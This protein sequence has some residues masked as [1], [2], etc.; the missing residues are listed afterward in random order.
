MLKRKQVHR[1]IRFVV[2]AAL[3]IIF[4]FSASKTFLAYRKPVVQEKELPVYKYSQTGKINYRAHL[5][6]NNLYPAPVLEPGGIYLTSFID[7]IETIFTYEF[8]GDKNARIYGAYD[9]S[10]TLEAYDTSKQKSVKIWEKTFPL[11]EQKRFDSQGEKASFTESVF[12]DIP[13]YN[14]F[15]EAVNKASGINAGEAKLIVRCNIYAKAQTPDGTAEENIAPALTIPVGS[16]A[17]SIGPEVVTQKAGKLNKKEKFVD[18][19]VKKEKYIFS[20]VSALILIIMLVFGLTTVG[21]SV[22]VDL[23]KKMLAAIWKKHGDRIVKAKEKIMLETDKTVHLNSLEDVVKMADEL[24]RPVF[25]EP[26]HGTGLH[27]FYIFDGYFRYECTV[28]LENFYPQQQ[29]EV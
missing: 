20:T 12:L 22:Q 25:Y 19:G 13:Y 3:L 10:A 6:P 9:I 26:R 1:K 5:K 28:S 17:F 8:I 21:R 16:K 11:G 24:G 2:L 14:Q 27:L 29:E 18:P 7:K 4:L 15:L 23:E